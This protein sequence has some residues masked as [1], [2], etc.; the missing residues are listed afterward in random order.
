MLE[1]GLFCFSRGIHH[2]VGF[3]FLIL[4]F[5]N[6]SMFSVSNNNNN[7]NNSIYLNTIKSYSRADVVV[8][9]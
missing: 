8:C 4:F 7:N 5:R 6:V 1:H 3:R 9:G 2:K